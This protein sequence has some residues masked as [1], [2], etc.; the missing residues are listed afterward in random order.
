[1][2]LHLCI[3]IAFGQGTSAASAQEFKVIPLPQPAP[4][5]LA[6][7][8]RGVLA[9]TGYRVVNEKGKPFAEF[10]LRK[11]T[12]A[13]EPPSGAKGTV[14]FPILAEGELLGAIRYPG[15]GQ[16]YHDQPIPPGVYTIRYGLQPE[17]GAHLGVSPFRDYALLLPAAKDRD[18]AVIA[19]KT[20][21][22]EASAEASGTTHPSVLMLLAPP[23][24]AKDEPETLHDEEKSLWGAIVPL[25][26]AVKGAGSPSRLA[27]GLVVS[28][29][30][31]D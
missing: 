5:A 11:G 26:L 6:E 21:L 18:T 28:G 12:P 25:E 2:R 9:A 13:S 8:V 27:I 31:T 29:A 24:P 20:R 4:V 1:M 30:H 14:Q 19:T 17:N 23:G 7:P 15:E 3:L 16:D 10:W 22:Q